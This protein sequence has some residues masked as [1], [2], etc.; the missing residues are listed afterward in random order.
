LLPSGKT[1]RRKEDGM[2]TVTLGA[3]RLEVT[4]LAHGTGPFG[5]EVAVLRVDRFPT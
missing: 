1:G 2:R 5:Q 4:P 3:F